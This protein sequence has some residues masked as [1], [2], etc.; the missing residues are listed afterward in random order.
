MANKRRCPYCKTYN[1]PEDAVKVNISYFCSIVCATKYG[2]QNKNKGRDIKHREQKKEF[3][4][5]DKQLRLKCAQQAFNAFIRERDKLLGC[6]SCDKDVN[7][8]GQ[9]HAGHYK[10]TKARP[11]IRFN[12][13]NCHKQCSVCNNH[14]SGNIG[15]YTPRLIERIGHD[16]F[17]ALGLNKVRR[18]ECDE[19]KEIEL[20]YKRKLKELQ[21]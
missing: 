18:Y 9:W 1:K 5:N 11:D 16:R 14:L 12:E 2:Y 17:L 15:E 6:I 13:D 3:I 19:L 8:S 7:W 10:T 20:L 21:E 4:A